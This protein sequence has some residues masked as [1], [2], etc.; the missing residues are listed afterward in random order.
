MRR[1]VVFFLVAQ[2]SSNWEAF[3]G[4]SAFYGPLHSHKGEAYS[5]RLAFCFCC[6][7]GSVLYARLSLEQHGLCPAWA[8]LMETG[9]EDGLLGPSGAHQAALQFKGGVPRSGASL[10]Q[11]LMC[12]L[13]AGA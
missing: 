3:Y 12:C 4:T 7:P 6:T 10:L 1:D 2:G 13:H 5:R 11:A 8:A 9:Q